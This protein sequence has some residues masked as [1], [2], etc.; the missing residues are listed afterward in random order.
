MQF[1]Q[2][3]EDSCT[4]GITQVTVYSALIVQSISS[5]KAYNVQMLQKA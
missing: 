4:L 2:T 1:F 3:R 5:V